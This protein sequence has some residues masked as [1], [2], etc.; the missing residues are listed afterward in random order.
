MAAVTYDYSSIEPL[1]DKSSIFSAELHALYLALERV[2]TAV[3][4]ERNFIIFSDLKSDLQAISGRDWTHAFVLKVME[5][6]HWL[7]KYQG[8]EYYSIRFLVMLASEVMRRRMLLPKMASWKVTNI[9]IPYG[10]LKKHINVFLK[11]KWQ[12]Q[13][14]EAVNNKLHEIHP[15]LGLW[16]G[17]S[18][19]IRHEE[20]VLARIRIGHTYLTH[21]FHLKKGRSSP[22]YS[23]WLSFDCQTYFI[24][25]CRFYGIRK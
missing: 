18:W 2:E 23:L 25:L 22:M 6:L 8:K 1:P 19:I 7:I 24:W 17:G 11:H 12:S 13:W 21:S 20:S 15:Q 3:D 16:P 4:D 14:D 10:D 5:C 9:P